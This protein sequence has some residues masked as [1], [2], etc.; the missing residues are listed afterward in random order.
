MAA[1]AYFSQRVVNVKPHQSRSVDVTFTVPEGTAAQGLV[2][3][4]RGMDR[5]PLNEA[6]GM[7]PSMGSLIV[8]SSPQ[9]NEAE[10]GSAAGNTASSFSVAQWADSA[11][12]PRQASDT[13]AAMGFGISGEGQ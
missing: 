12:A 7:T 8:I 4:F 3:G 9:T 1:T 2:I 11:P 13:H 6:L 5:L 10:A